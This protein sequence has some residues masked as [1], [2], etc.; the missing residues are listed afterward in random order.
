MLGVSCLTLRESTERPVTVVEGTNKVIG[1]DTDRIVEESLSVLKGHPRPARIPELWD[2]RGSHRRTIAI[3]PLCV[4][5]RASR[6]RRRF[7]GGRPPR[8]TAA[9]RAAVAGARPLARA[10]R[11]RHVDRHRR[12]AGD[13]AA[14]PANRSA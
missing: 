5:L 6:G 8:A 9:A 12:A 1:N 2:G 14:R 4:R 11:S 10:C 7:G 3:G 13:S